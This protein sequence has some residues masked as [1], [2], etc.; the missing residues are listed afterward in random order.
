MQ[1]GKIADYP[2][3]ARSNNPVLASWGFK[4]VSDKMKR[5][6][7]IDRHQFGYLTDTY[8]YCR[9]LAGRYAITYVGWDYGLPT[10]SLEGVQVISVE[11]T[12]G[13][14][15]R[16]GRYIL[17]AAREMRTH[18]H[19]LVFIVLFL[20]CSLL[21]FS[22]GATPV[23]IDIRTG[24]EKSG[25]LSRWLENLQ[26]RVEA[27]AFRHIS[28][29]SDSLRKVLRFP[30]GRCYILP[31]GAEP[32]G[33]PPRQFSDLRL[34]Y[35]GTLIQR[36]IEETVRGVE[37]FHRSVG[38]AVPITYD[39]VGDG[40]R[41]DNDRLTDAIARSSCKESI[42]YHG[43]VPY[44]RLRPFLE[45]VNVGVAFVPMTPYFHCQ[46]ATKIFEYL[47]AGMPVMATAT[48]ENRLVVTPD[49]GIL[50][51]DT[52]E[53]FCE[54]LH[55]LADSLGTYDSSHITAAATRYSWES[56]VRDR[57][58]PMLEQVLV[59]GSPEVGA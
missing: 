10:I 21:R 15:R 54:G 1:I 6:L 16:L 57:L 33:L 50:H 52:A 8:S 31:L 12:G 24:S 55:R 41:A 34:L 25:R 43:R 5:L 46:P 4:R 38:N 48:E 53:G 13:Q 17:R 35:V 51:E 44:D 45:R 14:A 32:Q 58:E 23:V 18:N 36:H 40:D 56:I 28:I 19:D 42:R 59:P 29:I 27:S 3:S 7:I 2:W 11:R 37:L 9:H 49:L 26:F 20:G 30:E 47:L 39:I 22:G